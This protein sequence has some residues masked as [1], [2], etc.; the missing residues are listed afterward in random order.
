MTRHRQIGRLIDCDYVF[1][2]RLQL[3]I[4]EQAPDQSIQVLLRASPRGYKGV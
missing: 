4:I 3:N 2:E 1:R